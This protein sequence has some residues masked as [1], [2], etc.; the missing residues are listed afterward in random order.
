MEIHRVYKGGNGGVSLLMVLPSG[1]AK[2]LGIP[3]ATTSHW[4]SKG[5]GS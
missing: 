3:R 2:E 4:K 1:Q 5:S